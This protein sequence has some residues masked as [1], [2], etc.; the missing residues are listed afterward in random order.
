MGVSGMGSQR[1]G[2]C[3]GAHVSLLRDLLHNKKH[4]S[5]GCPQGPVVE[6]LPSDA[7]PWVQFLV[8]EPRSH[9][10]SN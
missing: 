10:P 3:E 1:C 2:R 8:N 5:W 9:T 7:A 4:N 6:T